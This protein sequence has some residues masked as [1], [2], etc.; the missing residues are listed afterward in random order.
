MTKQVYCYIR[1]MTVYSLLCSVDKLLPCMDSISSC[2][3]V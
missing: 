2:I 1:M 3:P